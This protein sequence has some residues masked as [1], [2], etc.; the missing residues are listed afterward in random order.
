MH[1]SNE[2]FRRI[3]TLPH[4][5]SMPV[6]HIGGRP[7]YTSRPRWWP[8]TA[9]VTNIRTRPHGTAPMP[10]FTTTPLVSRTKRRRSALY[11]HQ[12]QRP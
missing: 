2:P 12:Y 10:H 8:A 1:R 5:T 6:P 7:H 11:F 3:E 4:G 9:R